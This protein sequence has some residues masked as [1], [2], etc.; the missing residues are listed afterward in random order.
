LKVDDVVTLGKNEL[1]VSSCS[2]LDVTADVLVAATC[3]VE[4]SAMGVTLPQKYSVAQSPYLIGSDE[5]CDLQLPA[6]DI[7]PIHA[8][9]TYA[10]SFWQINDLTGNR[11]ERLTSRDNG[12]AR[13]SVAVSGEVMWI[14]AL[15]L[16][17]HCKPLDRV[18]STMMAALPTVP[19]GYELKEPAT[20]GIKRR[21]TPTRK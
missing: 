3:E 12:R 18:G 4:V 16:A 9:L 20:S 11:L 21:T 8:M 5:C 10:D 19:E 15:Q 17:V 13:C 2:T 1:R 14:G 7:E 6:K